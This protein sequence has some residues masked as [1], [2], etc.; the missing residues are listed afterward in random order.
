M[1]AKILVIEDDDFVTETIK[2]L[3]EPNGFDVIASQDGADIILKVLKL[4][5]HLILTDIHL[6]DFDGRLICRSIKSN[7]DTSHIP[8][9][10][11]S[12][13]TSQ[14]YNAIDNVG[15]NDVLAKPFNEQTLLQRVQRQ[16]SA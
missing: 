10:I 1:K 8:V 11:M 13:D 12:G 15:A 6:G 2:L 3:L 5:P 16:I 4:N 14:I 7:P 9:I